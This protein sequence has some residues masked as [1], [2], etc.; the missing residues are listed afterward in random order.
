[1]VNEKACHIQ[2]FLAKLLGM[3]VGGVQS[4]VH[5]IRNKKNNHRVRQ[6]FSKNSYFLV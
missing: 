6:T 1:M 4:S 3:G 2:A 5:D